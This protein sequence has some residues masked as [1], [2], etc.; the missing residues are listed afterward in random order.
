MAKTFSVPKLGEIMGDDSPTR[1]MLVDPP[2]KYL[3][4]GVERAWFDNIRDT[5]TMQLSVPGKKNPDGT[6]SPRAVSVGDQYHDADG[7]VGR[8][9]TVEAYPDGTQIVTVEMSRAS[10]LKTAAAMTG[11]YSGV[12]P[13]GVVI[14]DMVADG[15]AAYNAYMDRAEEETAVAAE[16]ENP[17]VRAHGWSG[18][19]SFIAKFRRAI[20][21]FTCEDCPKSAACVLRPT[22]RDGVRRNREAVPTK[23]CREAFADHLCSLLARGLFDVLD[24]QAPKTPENDAR[25]PDPTEDTTKPASGEKYAHCG[26]PERGK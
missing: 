17:L 18:A 10:M 21:G 9:K 8:V 22:G 26:S 24:G 1:D 6:Y 7:V 5:M 16:R 19:A 15:E 2:A 4:R 3:K 14:D 25:P 13:T 20:L 12:N 23:A 11:R